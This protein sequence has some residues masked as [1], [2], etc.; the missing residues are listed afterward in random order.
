MITDS[1]TFDILAVPFG[2]GKFESYDKDQAFIPPLP[3]G[4]FYLITEAGE[5][6]LTEAGEYYITNP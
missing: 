3:P 4:S 6:L 2:A 5:F 1:F